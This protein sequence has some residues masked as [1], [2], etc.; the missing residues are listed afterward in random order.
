[1][2]ID[3]LTLF[4]EMFRETLGESIIARGASKGLLDLNFFQIR[5]YTEDKQK[6]VDDYP[7]GGGPGLVMSYQPIVSAYHAAVESAGGLKPHVIYMTPQGKVHNQK[8]AKRLSKLPYVMIICGHY[9]GIDERAY[10]LA[11]YLVSLGDYVITSGELASMIVIDAV[12]RKLDGVLGAEGGAD[13]E[14]FAEGL[15]E[16]PQYTRPAEFLGKAVPEV[17]LSG[18]HEAIARW[19]H[20]QSLLRTAVLRPDLIEH[21]NLPENDLKFLKSSLE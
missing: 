7:Y 3:F 11:D 1:M 19:K 6:K 13:E 21:G 20:E 10:D 8:I 2:R 16:H 18:N 17:L 4:P 15:L 9:E 12:I 5:D 14:S